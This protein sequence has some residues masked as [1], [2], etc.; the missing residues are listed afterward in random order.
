MFK[1]ILSYLYP[2]TIYNKS[3][4]ISKSLEV[5]YYNGKKMLNTANTNYSYGSL[6]TILKK[7][8]LEIGQKEIDTLSEI[9]ILGVAGGSVVHT[10]VNDFNFKKPITGIE[11]D[12]EVIAIANSHF[13]LQTFQNFTCIL[14]DAEEFVRNDKSKYDL[15]VIDIFKDIEMPAFLFENKFI[16][17]IKQM[18]DVNSF[19][20]F[21]IMIL[22]KNKEELI[23]NYLSHFNSLDYQ[24]TQLKKVEKYNDLLII[25]RIS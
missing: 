21:N 17:N 12:A 23:R 4:R 11:I 10:L 13:N 6:E 20:L 14:A 22:D 24:I 2:I 15:I 9:L 1:K 16:E 3:S 5:T 7:G 18:L 8:L 19:I 25:K